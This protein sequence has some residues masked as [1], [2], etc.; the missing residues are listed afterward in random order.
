MS[1]H[2]RHPVIQ[3]L[4]RQLRQREEAR[5][6]AGQANA[7]ASTG[8]AALDALLVPEAFRPGMIIEWVVEGTG[9]GAARLALPAATEALQNGGALVVIDERR[10]F[11]PPAA[12]RLGL[13]LER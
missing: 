7:T 3:E 9:S 12:A 5:P 8:V 4:R 10:E 6:R 13:D 11:Y 2:A 1:T